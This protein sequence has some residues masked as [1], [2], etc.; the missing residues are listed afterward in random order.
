MKKLLCPV[1]PGLNQSVELPSDEAKHALQVFRLRDGDKVIAMDGK[2][3][4][5]VATLRTASDKRALIEYDSPLELNRSPASIL[6]LTVELAIL[7]GQAMEWAIEKAVELGAQKVVP[8]ITDHAVVQIDRKGPEAFQQR[9]QKI[10]DQALKQCGRTERLSVEPPTRLVRLL[11][12]DPHGPEA[13]RLWCDEGARG[14]A[15]FLLDWLI[16]NPGFRN[17]RILI[18]PEGGWSQKERDLLSSSGRGISLGPLVLRAET[19]VLYATSLVSGY[20]RASK[21]DKDAPK[22]EC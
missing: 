4:A 5:I 7:K 9:W 17:L 6:P 22:K 12:S 10:A 3:H 13:P 15:P 20:L 2:G 1:L 8:V 21:L 16:G 18:G 11:E 19:A 14:E